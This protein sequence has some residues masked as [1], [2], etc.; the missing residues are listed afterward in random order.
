MSDDAKAKALADRCPYMFQQPE[1]LNLYAGWFGPIEK[2]CAEI[3][4]RLQGRGWT[5][6]FVQIKEKFGAC[7]I[8]FH[9]GLPP[10][11]LA[12][13]VVLQELAV[14][15]MAIESNIETAQAACS[16]SCM[17]C[18]RA[19][20]TRAYGAL[21]ATLCEQHELSETM[22]DPWSLAKLRINLTTKK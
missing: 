19:A 10:S 20:A 14:H 8:Y 21:L 7:R 3:D 6:R 16:S 22:R 2:L 12:T 18:G 1:M 9:L 11:D 4:E 5:F 15:R 13:S 17:V